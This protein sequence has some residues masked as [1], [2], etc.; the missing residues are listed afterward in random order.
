MLGDGNLQTFSDGK[1]FRLRIV[2]S[3]EHKDYCF[4]LYEIFKPYVQTPP[5]LEQVYDKRTKKTYLRWTFNTLTSEDFTK[6][7]NLFYK[8]VVL[9]DGNVS[10]QKKVP[11]NI[12]ELLTPIGI[13]YWYMDDGAL[14]WKDNSNAVRFCTECF[15]SHELELLQKCFSSHELEL[16]QKCLQQKFQLKTTLQKKREGKVIY[17]PEKQYQTLAN[18]IKKH[19]ISSMYGKFPDGNYGTLA[20]PRN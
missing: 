16:L 6:V 5:R 11:E 9:E 10:W 12:A 19:L 3:D 1:T 14:K 13:A 15:S 7:G 18:L 2:Q 8:R 20:N 4:H 17:V